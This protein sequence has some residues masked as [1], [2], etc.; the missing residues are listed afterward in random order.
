[1]SATLWPRTFHL[2]TKKPRPKEDSDSFSVVCGHVVSFTHLC[3]LCIFGFHWAFSPC[4]ALSTALG[5][6]VTNPWPPPSKSSW[7]SD[8]SQPIDGGTQILILGSC[9]PTPS[10]PIHHLGD[11]FSKPQTLSTLTFSP[12]SSTSNTGLTKCCFS[13]NKSYKIYET[14]V[15]FFKGRKWRGDRTT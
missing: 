9:P 8:Q 4:R 15:F 12:I 5:Y 6:R 1:M 11:N 2:Q 13:V 3:P 10:F 7:S 14:E